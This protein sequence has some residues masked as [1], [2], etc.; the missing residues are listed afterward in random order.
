MQNN[1][2]SSH[3]QPQISV[4]TLCAYFSKQLDYLD[5]IIDELSSIRE[6]TNRYLYEVWSDVKCVRVDISYFLG[7]LK[8]YCELMQLRAQPQL[9][10]LTVL[11]QILTDL[12]A[13]TT[14]FERKE[15]SISLLSFWLDC[16]GGQVFLQRL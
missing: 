3:T 8:E 14:I 13:M 9:K 4:D 6:G 12:R 11:D 15:F 5:S 7:G 10:I 1:H 2:K 16:T